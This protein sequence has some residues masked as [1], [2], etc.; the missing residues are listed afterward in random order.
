MQTSIF[1]IV[2]V[3]ILVLPVLAWARSG[4]IKSD[5]VGCLSENALDEF[6]GAAVEKDYRQM[7][8]LVEARLCFS[9]KGREYSTVDVGFVTSKIR[10]YAG[11]GSVVLY[12]PTEAIRK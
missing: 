6:I 10:V 5:Y 1:A 12:V 8:V 9:L 7:Q 4:T 3:A 2:L 11:G